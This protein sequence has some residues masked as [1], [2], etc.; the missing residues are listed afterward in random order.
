MKSLTHIDDNTSWTII[1]FSNN[2]LMKLIEMICFQSCGS[3][4]T[5]K[6]AT[7]GNENGWMDKWISFFCF[8][9]SDADFTQYRKRLTWWDTLD[10]VLLHNHTCYKKTSRNLPREVEKCFQARKMKSFS[11]F[12][13]PFSLLSFR[14]VRLDLKQLNISVQGQSRGCTF[15]ICCCYGNPFLPQVFCEPFAQ[16]HL[17]YFPCP[18]QKRALTTFNGLSVNGL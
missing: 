11:L 3:P 17:D 10:G 9:N 18:V 6:G 12:Y 2:H 1:L 13:I 4:M 8:F 15:T 14:Q 5:L 16:R 7:A